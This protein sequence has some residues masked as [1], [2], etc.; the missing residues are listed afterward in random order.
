M[1]FR[2]P[3][4]S[5]PIFKLTL[6]IILF[7]SIVSVFIGMILYTNILIKHLIDREKTI[8]QSYV[9]IY[10]FY[11][12][13]DANNYEEMFFFLESITPSI[14]FPIVTT[15]INGEPLQDYS[16]Y[17]LNTDVEKYKTQEEQREYLLNLI[18]DM[19][20]SYKPILVYDHEGNVISK[21]Y[22]SH[23]NL[24][25]MLK[26]FPF[27]SLILISAIIGIGYFAL[28]AERNN[29]Q[30]KIWIGMAR[31]TAHQLGTP[32]SSLLAWIEILKTNKDDP[33]MIDYA[34]NEIEN[35]L[36]R[37]NTIAIR[38][39]KIGSLPDKKM[40]DIDKT[41]EEVTSYY[42]KRLPHISNKVTI[43]KSFSG[44]T[45]IYAN[46]MLMTW[47]F[48]N[49]IKNA[50]EAMEGQNG[51]IDISTHELSSKKLLI[52]VKD[53][54]K[55]MT[56]KM[57]FQIFEPGF[58]TKKRGWGIGLNL[59]KR[60]IEEYHNGKVYVKESTLKKGTTFAIELPYDSKKQPNTNNK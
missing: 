44:R 47:V 32:L 27:I 54:G 37:L 15:D 50:A 40:I 26:Y 57:R 30:S 31:E 6:K 38:F 45:Q 49:L 12:S 3:K 33:S 55:G 48:E 7:V 19:E 60:I 2:T 28:A 9:Q 8:M 39:S 20:K 52:L 34:A 21:F 51:Q 41:I 56:K 35:D 25:E 42:E 4:L 1:I 22:Y 58:T 53:T 59:V 13:P 36:N 23:S 14:A 18:K 17:T 24:I 10:H 11:L 46:N 43:S 5:S 29:E 16:L